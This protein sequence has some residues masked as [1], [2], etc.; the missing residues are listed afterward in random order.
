MQDGKKFSTHYVA[1]GRGYRL[2]PQKELITVYPKDGGE[3]RKASFVESFSKEEIKSSNIRYFF[4]EGCKLGYEVDAP[5]IKIVKKTEAVTI[6]TKTTTT[7]TTT[8]AEPETTTV[9]ESQCFTQCCD[10]EKARIVL[11]PTRTGISKI[12]I[13]FET[14]LL[15]RCSVNEIIEIT[16]EQNNIQLLKKL[17]KFA[18]RYKL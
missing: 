12:V 5:P 14:E 7:T 3:P 11:S 15:S 6:P 10:E 8:T 13:P 16:T 4:P 1:D 2:V 17:L 18:K 9:Q